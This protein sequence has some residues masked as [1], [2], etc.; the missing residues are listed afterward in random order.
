MNL[1]IKSQYG[2]SNEISQVVPFYYY[3]VRY[4]PPAQSGEYTPE[5]DDS[6]D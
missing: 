2:L 1:V 6:L 3:D 4:F 5:E